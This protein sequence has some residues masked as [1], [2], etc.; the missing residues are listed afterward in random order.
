MNNIGALDD[1]GD[2]ELNEVSIGKGSY[3]LFPLDF[4][5]QFTDQR[6][7]GVLVSKETLM[8]PQQ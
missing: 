1:H 5:V 7:F 8:L 3:F 2:Q 4:S 6:S